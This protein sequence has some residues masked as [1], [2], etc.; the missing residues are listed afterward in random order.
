EGAYEWLLFTSTNAVEI[1]FELL[2]S[3]GLD[4]RSVR[5][6]VGVIGAA[7][8]QALERRGIAVDAKPDADRYTAEGLLAALQKSDLQGMRV[9]LPR[10]EGARELLIEGLVERGAAVDEVTL[11]VAA[12]PEDR[13]SEG[14]RRLRAGEI[15]IATFASSST[16][17][18]LAALLGDDL[19]PLRR[20]RIA[21]IGP[22]TAA[23]VEELLGRP[24]DVV[25]KEHTI[26]GLMRA[27]EET[28]NAG[29]LDMRARMAVK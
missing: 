18:N 7:T 15:D 12:L 9:L 24:P 26:S 17:R 28:P 10:A 19:E 23:T 29:Q 21:C 2:W 16:V 27:L 22:I 14:L 1:F 11:Y 25:A 4:A 20:C 13:D 5:A 8:A 6:R 3:K